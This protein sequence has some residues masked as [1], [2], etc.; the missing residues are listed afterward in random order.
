MVRSTS[1]LFAFAFLASLVAACAGDAG[2]SGESGCTS[3]DDCASGACVDGA[4]VSGG[5]AGV[6]TGTED[7]GGGGEDVDLSDAADTGGGVDTG[8][9]DVTEDTGPEPGSFAAPCDSGED[10]D[11][12][13]CIDIG[14]ESVCTVPCTDEC[15]D[16]E[17]TCELLPSSGGDLSQICVPPRDVLCTE[18]TRDID[19]G[20]LADLCIAQNDGSWCGTAC[21]T[22]AD[23][24]EGYLCDG[25]ASVGGVSSSQC[26]PELGICGGCLDGDGDEYGQ[27]PTCFGE[28]CDEL[29]PS[30]YEG[31]PELCDG[32]DNDC[33]DEIDEGFDFTTDARHCGACGNNC[34]I[35]HG[36]SD[37]VDSA[38]IITSCDIG[39][40]DLNGLW[41]DDCEYEC[42]PNAASGGT[43]LC[44]G[45]DDDCD[46]A[47][48]EDFDTTSDPN[49]CGACGNACDLPSASA[50]CV[51]SECVID[52]CVDPMLHCN[53]SQDDGC[54]VDPRSDVLNCGDCGTI[55]RANNGTPGCEDSSCTIA[56][57]DEFYGDCDGLADARGCETDLRTSA[58]NCGACDNPCINPERAIAGCR[59][60]TT[61]CPEG[62]TCPFAEC[63]VASCTDADY[64][65]CNGALP[66]GFEDGCESYRLDP[67][68]CLSC[69]NV[70]AYDNGIAGCNEAG[71]FLDDCVEGWYDI[72]DDVEDGCEYA[73]TPS[74]GGVEI[75]DGVDNDCN[76]EIDDD[77]S[78]AP[79]W[80]FDFDGDTFGDRG[81]QLRACVRP[82]RYVADNRDCNDNNSEI[83]P[84][85]V[86][87]CDNI[88][89][90][91]DTQRDE[92][93]SQDVDGDGHYAIG[94]CASPADDCNDNERRTY[95][96]NVESCDGVDNDCNGSVDPVSSVGCTVY[97][98]DA[99][100]DSWGVSTNQCL[101]APSGNYRATRSGDCYDGNS[102]A[103]PGQGGWFTSNRGDGSYDYNCDGNTVRQWTQ[104]GGS[105][106]F[107]S[108]FCSG[109]SD[110]GW[111]NSAPGCGSGG[112]W[113]SDC[114]YSTSGAPWNWGCYWR[115]S[116]SRTQACQ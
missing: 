23:C 72:N 48:D 20:G 87:I 9:D 1:S 17:W 79:L 57:C 76:G 44:N 41:E 60:A 110:Q 14:G 64:L 111:R 102:S 95:P 75:C 26:V 93:L 22:T 81:E 8:D 24:P 82:D 18:C 100:N 3:D 55:C 70:C 38:C 113:V 52:V 15:P 35:E 105:C 19:C 30:T 115:N 56:G 27:G 73:C 88:D 116:S 21:E 11:S 92:G 28:D 42:T 46:G 2:V 80:Y 96:G 12:G 39:W 63:Y 45:I 33:D 77:A 59:A 84:S 62:E 37:C 98:V 49:N 29:D 112:T 86:E 43:E 31:A 114:Y 109:G 69:G 85:A 91:C 13:I 99:D 36:A 108:D 89:N 61:E 78:D 7:T 101:C 66:G 47:I 106:A 10:C 107:F 5:D 40:Y 97:Y 103:R 54:E 25:V 51:D 74:N 68:S 71:C 67:N 53:A 58:A 32:V 104:V 4:C 90:N 6:D 16:P 83:N 50:L 94:S 34:A 65:D